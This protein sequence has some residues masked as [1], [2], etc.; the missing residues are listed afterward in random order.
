MKTAWFWGLFDDA[1]IF[2]DADGFCFSTATKNTK[3]IRFLGEVA[4]KKPLGGEEVFGPAIFG[5]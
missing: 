2:Q 4:L 3:I 5:F 1:V